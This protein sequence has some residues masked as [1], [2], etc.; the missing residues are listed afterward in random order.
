[1]FDIRRAIRICKRCAFRSPPSSELVDERY[2]RHC[3]PLAR[4]CSDIRTSGRANT[5]RG[6]L[7]HLDV[8]LVEI[9]VDPIG[10]AV[11]IPHCVELWRCASKSGW[12]TPTLTKIK[13]LC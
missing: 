4:V 6:Q 5:T 1:T 7:C 10:V 11:K 8:I 9:I 12:K 3:R 2:L 13:N